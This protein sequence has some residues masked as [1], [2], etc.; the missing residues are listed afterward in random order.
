MEPTRN[1][2]AVDAAYLDRQRAW[3][4]ETFG[5]GARTQQIIA[6]IRQE[7][8]EIAENPAD[9]TEWLDVVIL[10]LD[11]AWRTG[12]GSQEVL[13]ALAAK[14]DRNEART[15]P[16]WRTIPSTEPIRHLT[17]P[18]APPPTSPHDGA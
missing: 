6:H 14:R 10:A 18:L 5:P 13:D 7:L 15:W 12:L 4:T 1:A 8:E 11:G 17:D 9:V 3:S 16:D 2:A